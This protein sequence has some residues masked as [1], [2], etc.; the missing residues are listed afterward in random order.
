MSW[1]FFS[2]EQQAFFNDRLTMV[3]YS[4]GKGKRCFNFTY[5]AFFSLLLSCLS[6]TIFEM[7]DM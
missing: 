6:Q 7:T 4:G 3:A 1:Y 5:I 2:A